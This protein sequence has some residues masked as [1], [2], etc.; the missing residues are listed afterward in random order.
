M[1]ALLK[2]VSLS[3]LLFAVVSR[4]CPL[5]LRWS[6][7][8]GLHLPSWRAN[9]VHF[10]ASCKSAEDSLLRVVV[11]AARAC[12]DY[13]FSQLRPESDFSEELGPIFVRDSWK[14][15]PEPPRRLSPHETSSS[16]SVPSLRLKGSPS[17]SLRCSALPP[18]GVSNTINP[19]SGASSRSRRSA[20]TPRTDTDLSS[21][22][23]TSSDSEE[24]GELSLSRGMKRLTIRGLEPAQD[25]PS[26]PDSQVRFHGKSS[27]FKL[28]ETTRKLRDEHIHRV[29]GGD[30]R[31]RSS[32]DNATPVNTAALRRPEFWTTPS[33]SR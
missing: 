3:S 20:G 8:L 4:P 22:G 15:D 2:R 29:T 31:N 32:H 1:E 13:L 10:H 23:Y 9:H 11:L 28:I 25:N 27:Y 33:V 26:L 6:T 16:P 24:I 21:D 14:T 17:G 30:E 19:S 5:P 18:V 7:T 12:F